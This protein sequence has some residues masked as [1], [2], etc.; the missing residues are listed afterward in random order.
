MSGY[1]AL[2]HPPFEGS[3]YGVAF[4]DLP[5]CTSAG[6]T[7]EEAAINT[8][9]ALSGHLALMRADGEAIPEPRSLEALQADPEAAAG[10]DGAHPHF[11]APRS[12][13]ASA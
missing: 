3:A 4:P 5:G 11:V 7:F 6:D 12:F 10:L 2:I 8:R 1:I 13:T 9:E